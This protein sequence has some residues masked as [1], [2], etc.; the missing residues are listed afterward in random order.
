[1]S[2]F[3]CTDTHHAAAD[4][5]ELAQRF[6]WVVLPITEQDIRHSRR[7]ISDLVKTAHD[8][9]MEVWVGAW[10]IAGLFGG[11]GLSSI[12]HL[13][14]QSCRVQDELKR[15]TEVVAESG[16]EG[17]FLDEPRKRCCSINGILFDL[18]FVL[19]QAGIQTH[20]CLS[21]EHPWPDMLMLKGHLT[22]VGTDPYNVFRPEL[23]LVPYIDDWANEAKRAAKD[24]GA[25][26]HGWVRGFSVPA[27][28]EGAIAFS[29]K[30]WATA[31]V[32]RVGVW[33]YRPERVGTL[34][35]DQPEVVWQTISDTIDSLKN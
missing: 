16:A 29:L 35:N 15:W 9:G 17:A 1:M 25:Q 20:L 32:D 10:G 27:G 34:A 28:Q 3:G 30:L 4:F 13:C 6:S 8:A 22:S 5:K 19:S 2:Y 24:A 18:T 33:S 14:P 23:E 21:P 26:T 7:T 11:E 12:G 31:D